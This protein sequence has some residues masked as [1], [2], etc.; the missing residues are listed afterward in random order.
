[1]DRLNEILQRV[2]D[3]RHGVVTVDLQG[4]LRSLPG[5]EMDPALRPDGVHFTPESATELAPRLGPLVLDALEAEPVAGSSPSG[6]GDVASA[7][8]DAGG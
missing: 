5:G 7:A 8:G 2:A 6:E 1:M 3:E 4:L